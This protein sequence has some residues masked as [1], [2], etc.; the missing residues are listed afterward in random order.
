M[1]ISTAEV[2]NGTIQG[3]RREA[4]KQD[5]L[6]ELL[7]EECPQGNS[8]QEVRVYQPPPKGEGE[9]EDLKSSIIIPS[10]PLLEE[11]WRFNCRFRDDS[12]HDFEDIFLD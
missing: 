4:S 9:Q 3:G 12:R 8:L 7:R 11:L 5:D 2:Y 10:I 1:P 6:H